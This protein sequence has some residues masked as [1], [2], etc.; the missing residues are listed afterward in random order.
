MKFQRNRWSYIWLFLLGATSLVTVLFFAGEKLLPN[1]WC[2]IPSSA[3]IIA[4]IL[5]MFWQ[6]ILIIGGCM[7]SKRIK[8][9]FHSW[10]KTIIQVMNGISVVFL[11]LILAWNC[12]LYMLKFEQKVEQYDEHIALYVTNTFVRPRFRYPH[13]M[14]EE[15]GLFMR[16]LSDEEQN[17][18]VLKYGDPDHYYD[19][20]R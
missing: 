14:Y 5:C 8:T 2:Y 16:P 6:I 19:S 3:I 17:E 10:V 7:L 9:Y 1:G 11:V 20:D 12:F 15:N 4:F 18:A 13:Y